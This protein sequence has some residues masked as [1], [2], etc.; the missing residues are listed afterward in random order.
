MKIP[1][2]LLSFVALIILVACIKTF[3]D[4]APSRAY[5]I[6]SSNWNTI[7]VVF[8]CSGIVSKRIHNLEMGMPARGSL[9]TMPPCD[10]P[11][12]RVTLIG[13]SDAFVS[14]PIMG[15]VPGSTLHIN[16]ENSI[17]LTNWMVR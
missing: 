6:S 3:V 16:V 10:A 8:G 5:V 7:T 13:R 2:V 17:H 9:R 14:P 11:S 4:D 12:F 1:R 15:W